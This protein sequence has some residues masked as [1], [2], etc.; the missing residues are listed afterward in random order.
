ME[1][2]Q[3]IE[4]LTTALV[5]ARASFKPLTP[6][7]TNPHFRNAYA[8]LDKCLEVT[9]EGLGKHGLVVTQWL[10]PSPD[11]HM[12]LTTQVQHISGEWQRSTTFLPMAQANNPQSAGS[13]ITYARRYS[14]CAALGLAPDD[15]DD[16]EAA[17]P[18]QGD[19]RPINAHPQQDANL[20]APIP[21]SVLDPL[22]K[23]RKAFF[24]KAR[25]AGY[26]PDQ[27]KTLI[28]ENYE[29]ATFN[30]ASMDQL[31]HACDFLDKK[32]AAKGGHKHDENGLPQDPM[33]DDIPF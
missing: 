6:D 15:D 5:K 20:T 27:A 18:P 11:D 2:S 32:I 3:T 16:A 29:L 19:R 7:K 9:E 31:Q 25:D 12:G 22:E 14:Y 21:T 8:S 4:N 17:K 30:D 24:A 23:K 13:A 1:Q 10:E 33:G 28:K 26:T